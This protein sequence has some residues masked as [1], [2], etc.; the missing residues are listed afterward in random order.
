M[1]NTATSFLA[2]LQEDDLQMK[3]LALDKLDLLVD[4]HWAEISD[5]IRLFKD[6]YE[7]NILPD[8]QKL[9]ALILSKLY[10]NLEDYTSSVEWALKSEDKFDIKEN[11]LYVNTM[12]KKMLDQ[13]IQVRKHNFFN[14]DNQKPI[15]NKIVM[16]IENVFNNCLNDNR[17]SQALGFCIESY[18]LDRLTKAIESSKEIIKNIN[19]VY[20]ISQN[21]V[22]NKEYN[23]VL[24]DHI[25]KLL[26]K[27]ARKEYMEITSCQFFLN[28]S[29]AL[30]ST[31]LTILKEE[32]P[33]IAYQIAFDLYDHQN[34]SY[35]RLLTSTIRQINHD[36][37]LNLGDK[38]ENLINIL[39]G[40]I[41]R[42]IIM[43]TLKKF[44]H[45]NLKEQE[46][47]MKLVEKGSS[48]EI[49]GCLIT[50][51]FSNSHTLNDE[52]LKKN[53]NFV[54]KV[55][56]WA[57]FLV[58]ASLGAINMGNVKNSKQIF[59]DY[60]PG[61]T[62][63]SSQYCLGGAYYGIGLIHAGTNDH[64][65][66][67]FFREALARESNKKETVHHGIYLGIGLTA[68]ATHDHDLYE[69]VR[70]GIYSDD[71]IIGEAAGIAAGLIMAGS[72]DESAIDDLIKYAHDTQ[73]EKIIRAI[74]MALALIVYNAGEAA[75]ALIEQLTREKD[76]ILRYGAM[77]C[78]GLAYC[79]SG[80]TSMLQKL[81]KFSVSDVSD[82][83]RRAA[84]IN[85]GFLEIR[86]PDILFEN[87][88]VLELLSESYN[89]HVR[90][91]ATM[92]IGIACAGSGKVKPYKV[93]EPLFTDPNYLV[94]QAA[95]VAS[96][97]IFSQTTVK[98][99][100]GMKD[101]KENLSK[102]ISDKDEHLL[103][104]FGAFISKGLLN[105]GGKN[106]VINL[107]SN[108]NENKMKSI[109]G[110]CLFTQYYYWFPMILMLNLAVYPTFL[111]NLDDQLQLPKNYKMLSRSKPSI[112][113]YPKDEEKDEKKKEVKAEAAVLSTH[114]RYKAKTKKS[115][116]MSMNDFKAS[117]GLKS[118]SNDLVNAPSGK[119]PEKEE[120]KNEESKK[121]DK[122]KEKEKEKEEEIKIDT[123][124]VE[125]DEVELENPIR[126][127]PLQKKFIK[128]LNNNDFEPL[129]HGRY[130]GFVM[131][132]RK[133]PNV[134]SIYDE[135]LI[136]KAEEKKEEEKKEE[137]KDEKS[138][139][140]DTNKGNDDAYKS[141]PQEDFDIPEDF[142]IDKAK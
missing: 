127:L 28:N 79:G 135:E 131:L 23:A 101:F 83:V 132:K 104:K 24:I 21:Y 94:R 13:Y 77:Y 30:A 32:D 103:I 89:S 72:K 44:N 49:L 109:I 85:I 7:K 133:N 6:Y 92:A 18:D 58:T 102:V 119:I 45:S 19:F 140:G 60:L 129:I 87:L 35:L 114:I 71:A 142:D 38:L 41:P 69:F 53:M 42:N 2:L 4:Q 80:D 107:V 110:M 139:A 115:T 52:F 51:S 73:H 124:N 91:G 17:L 118:S 61:G 128:E 26:I 39:T 37:Q 57:R 113:G 106:C 66:M 112:F 99:E 82:D 48:L 74:A 95:L 125:P 117:S 8:K 15:D 10:Y 88:N 33:S 46:D 29:Q 130:S 86:S 68:M 59:R 63:A 126:I 75:D 12:L 34:P 55:T 25:L 123:S 16:I 27:H 56:N 138:N 93:I 137:K 105:L 20:E 134:I 78:I 141:V 31:L 70:E 40:E 14:R 84:L 54:R 98:Q 97:L 50:N 120:S 116:S 90:Y 5:Y 108:T 76:P 81:I 111:Y 136:D 43:R 47:L 96:G 100:E 22:V 1:I 64:E 65:I 11:S 36:K 67:S 9:L 62:R 121:D 122:E 3:S